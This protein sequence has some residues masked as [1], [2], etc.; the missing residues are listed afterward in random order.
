VTG[1]RRVRRGLSIAIAT[2]AVI[3]I[4]TGLSPVVLADGKLTVAPDHG[5]A[6]AKV[7]ASYSYADPSGACPPSVT[8]LWDAAPVSDGLTPDTSCSLTFSFLP[9]A[10]ADTTWHR[11]TACYYV[12][13]QCLSLGDFPTRAD[14]D[15]FVDPTPTLVLSKKAGQATT[16]FTA[17]YSTGEIPCRDAW[18]D[19]QFSWDGVVQGPLVSLAGDCRAVMKFDPVPN[20]NNVGK[21][22]VS[23]IACNSDGCQEYRKSATFTVRP[24]PT[25]TPSPTPTPMVTATPIATPTP[26]PTP[27]PTTAIP[28]PSEPPSPPPSQAV[29]E[30]TSPP[31]PTPSP[32]QGAVVPPPPPSSPNQYVPHIVAYIGGPDRGAIDPAVIATNVL[33]TLLVLFL[34]GLTA[35][36]FNS[37]MDANRVEVHGWWTRL[38]GRP[39]AALAALN[40]TGASLSRLSGTGRIG[41]I[42]RVLLVLSLLGII[43]GFLSPDFGWNPQSLILIVSLIIGCGFLTIFSE[44]SATRLAHNRYRAD[45]SIKLYGTAIVVAILAVVMSRLVDFSPGLVYGFIASAVIVAPVALARRDDATLVLVPAFGVLVI[46]LLAWL[47]LG[48][49]RAAAAGGEPLPALAETILGMIVIGGLEGLFITMIPLT[50]MDGAVVKAWSRLGWAI[51]FGLVTFLWWQLLL[52]QSASYLSAFE[53]TNVRVVLF[54]L[55][56]FMLTTGGL[57]SYFRFR[58]KPVEVETSS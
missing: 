31:G 27:S 11:V 25:P 1:F 7:N 13:S 33:L 10:P 40:F 37:T 9:P 28:T 18:P 51:V 42:A 38:F 55:A 50:F 41:S 12:R 3:V 43:Y 20:P 23:A 34:F 39:L 54:T 21:H 53:Q 48:P 19:A 47:L 32:D 45:A 30:A 5:K 58:P 16:S 22:S 57:W 29:L 15:Y 49:V 8:F 6:S 26:S 44:G 35:E 2:A 46:S 24:K 14:T 4:A 17:T 52:N 36:V 56:V